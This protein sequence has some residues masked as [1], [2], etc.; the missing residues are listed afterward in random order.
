MAKPPPPARENSI[1]EPLGQYLLPTHVGFHSAST[2]LHARN[3]REFR[4]GLRG[5]R[6]PKE[7]PRPQRCALECHSTQFQNRCGGCFHRSESSGELRHHST[8]API[9]STVVERPTPYLNGRRIVTR[10]CDS[11]AVRTRKHVVAGI[12]I[13]ELSRNAPATTTFAGPPSNSRPEALNFRL[14]RAP[15]FGSTCAE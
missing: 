12:V 15:V 2:R 13:I 4:G 10:A 3:Q 14:F 7:I 9:T 5:F 6:R 1:I 8:N 11:N